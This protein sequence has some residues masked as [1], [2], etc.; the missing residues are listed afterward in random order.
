VTIG[1]DSVVAAGSVVARS[2]PP[3]VLAAG[4]P[5][6]PVMTIQ[7]YAEWSLAA[8]PEYDEADFVRDKKGLLARLSLRGS[9][10]KRYHR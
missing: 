1:P 8:T 3:G 10:P 5:A 9:T 2:V 6:K 4:N 7:Q